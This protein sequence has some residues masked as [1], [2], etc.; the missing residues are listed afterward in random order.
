MIDPSACS[1]S[2][3][4]ISQETPA[5]LEALLQRPKAEVHVHI[6]GAT[7]PAVFWQ[8]AQKNNV[9]LPA[10]T[11][12]EWEQFYHFKDFNH[13]IEVYTLASTCIQRPED[14]QALVLGF[15]ASQAEQGIVHSDAFL[16]SS[17]SLGKFCQS[18]WIACLKE[19]L[20]LGQQRYGVTV[21]LIPDISRELPHTQEAV[22]AFVLEGQ[23]AGVF[24]GLGLGGIEA[25]FPP[26]LFMETFAEARRHG[27]HVVAHAG[28]AAGP[29]SVW[30][31]LELLHAE[32]IGHGVRCLEDPVLVDYLRDHQIPIE[33]SPT[34]NYCT[35]VVP[36]GQPH[37][38]HAM[39][40]AGL[41]I[42]LNSDDPPMFGTTLAGEYALLYQ[43]GMSLSALEQLR[44]N[45]W[46]SAFKA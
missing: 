29:E 46:T 5:T 12:Q 31:A 13:F 27:L 14:Y 23:R 2:S 39:V 20:V 11:L 38:I 45:T 34:S 9:S 41:C 35:G 25:E 40:Q 32:R 10:N 30:Q 33:V 42:T 17:L 22:L 15:M 24:T 19:A 8:M 6:E 43:Q 37:P 36:K 16:S 3:S 1:L 26:R 28:E 18:E 4:K 21:N 7:P 44:L